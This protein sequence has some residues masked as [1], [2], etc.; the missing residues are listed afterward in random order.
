[1][2]DFLVDLRFD[3]VEDVIAVFDLGCFEFVGM[4]SLAFN[5]L[6]EQIELDLLLRADD[7][8]V[9]VNGVE[10]VGHTRLDESLLVENEV[11]HLL[12]K[13]ISAREFSYKAELLLACELE[14]LLIVQHLH[15][16]HWLDV[17]LQQIE[18]DVF[19]F[20]LAQQRLH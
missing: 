17:L 10:R 11:V 7:I 14:W 19:Y 12:L 2:G 4:D 18:E 1:M 9:G 15:L 5:F 8:A 20:Y 3:P 16:I 13:L 6:V